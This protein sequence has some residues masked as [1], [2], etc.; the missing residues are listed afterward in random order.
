MH[1]ALRTLPLV[2]LGL[3]SLSSL[4]SQSTEWPAIFAPKASAER[5]RTPARAPARV[6]T[7]PVSERVR[8]LIS[9]ASARVL[10]NAVAFHAPKA[11]PAMIV[12][13]ASGAMVMAPFVVRDQALQESQ[14]RRP[15]P[16]LFH[17]NPFGGDEHRRVIG[18]VTMP[19]YHV[20]IGEKEFQVDFNVVNGAGRGVDHGRDFNR[21]EIGFSLK[22]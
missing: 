17:F 5:P 22:W 15:S 2:A 1:A 3:C 7:S 19:L 18:G 12:D 20:F 6:G 10:E 4:R 21:A 11:A 9:A 14:V 16:R 8:S 13:E